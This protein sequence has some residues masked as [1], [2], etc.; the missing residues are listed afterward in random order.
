MT[1]YMAISKN[2]CPKYLPIF[3]LKLSTKSNSWTRAEDIIK[4]NRTRHPSSPK[5]CL[6]RLSHLFFPSFAPSY[7]RMIVTPFSYFFVNLCEC[8]LW[9]A[10]CKAL[11]NLLWRGLWRGLWK[12]IERNV[13]W[14]STFRR[15]VTSVKNLYK[16]SLGW[17]LVISNLFF[18]YYIRKS[19]EGPSGLF[20]HS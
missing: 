19:I 12:S 3:T 16:F 9:L 11:W 6:Q 1:I 8:P 18:N 20:N 4:S 14:R 7:D 2:T 10:L 13:K 5:L 17:D 15:K